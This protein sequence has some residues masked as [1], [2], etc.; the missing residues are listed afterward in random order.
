MRHHSSMI[1]LEAVSTFL[2]VQII[3]EMWPAKGRQSRQAIRHK[4]T[5][6]PTLRWV[7]SK[8]TKVQFLCWKEHTSPHLI[9]PASSHSSL[10]TPHLSRLQPLESRRRAS[11]T[12]AAGRHLIHDLIQPP[13]PPPPN[14]TTLTPITNSA[15]LNAPPPPPQIQ[16]PSSPYLIQPLSSPTSFSHSHPLPH[17]ASLTPTSLSQPQYTGSLLCRLHVTLADHSG[18]RGPKTSCFHIFHSFHGLNNK[19]LCPFVSGLSTNTCP[20]F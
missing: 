3:T 15:T 8:R 1:E 13:P 2:Y 12:H 5:G 16:P 19:S 17:S 20:L 4:V 6:W 10:T 9:L 11:N 18:Q 14:S 7:K